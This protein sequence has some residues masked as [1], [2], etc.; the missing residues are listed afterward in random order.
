MILTLMTRSVSTFLAGSV[1]TK[2]CMYQSRTQPTMREGDRE[3]EREKRVSPN[4]REGERIGT[5]RR[6]D[7]KGRERE[8]RGKKYSGSM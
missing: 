4:E 1:L 6:R 2:V 8:M 3:G 7:R 5:V